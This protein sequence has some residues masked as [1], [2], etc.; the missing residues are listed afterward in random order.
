MKKLMLTISMVAFAFAIMPV[1]KADD[2]PS[3]G[4]RYYPPKGGVPA[5]CEDLSCSG[6]Q[7]PLDCVL[8]SGFCLCVGQ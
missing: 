5:G 4:C 8:G 7:V 3:A 2:D 6:G 1:G